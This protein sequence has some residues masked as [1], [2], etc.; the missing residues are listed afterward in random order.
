MRRRN[1]ILGLMVVAARGT[2]HA[3]QRGKVHRIA[4][5]DPGL[6]ETNRD[7]FRSAFVNELRRLGYVEGD[8]LLIERYSGKGRA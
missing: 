7:P 4:I 3:Q 2:A 1:L 8:N 6:S 5:V